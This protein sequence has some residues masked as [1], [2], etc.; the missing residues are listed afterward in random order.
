MGKIM[1]LMDGKLGKLAGK[2]RFFLQSDKTKP[3]GRVQ[4]LTDFMTKIFGFSK[5]FLYQKI[6]RNAKF[7][8]MVLTQR[9]S[10]TMK[11]L[12]QLF[13]YLDQEQRDNP[14]VRDEIGFVFSALEGKFFEFSKLYNSLNELYNFSF[15]I[16]FV[17]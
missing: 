5:L 12:P 15:F 7:G 8:W 3:L 10:L 14:E 2:V 1:D 9:I 4:I 17:S 13:E 6:D 11:M 16:L